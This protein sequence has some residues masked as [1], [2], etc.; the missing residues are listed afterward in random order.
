SDPRW[1]AAGG[2]PLMLGMFRLSRRAQRD[3]LAAASW[4]AQRFD[5][6]V[7]RRWCKANGYPSF[8]PSVR[9]LRHFI[10]SHAP[11]YKLA[12]L[13][14]LGA[15]LTAMHEAAGQP[16]PLSHPLLRPVWLG[17]LRPRVDKEGVMVAETVD[18]RSA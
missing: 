12:T 6:R 11:R 13:R 7:W 10:R 3:R 15:T 17:A 14:R 8:N 9:Q 16:D 18:R 4:A 5:W 1:R 2:V